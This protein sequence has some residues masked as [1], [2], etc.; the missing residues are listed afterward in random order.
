[1]KTKWNHFCEKRVS[2]GMFFT[3]FHKSHFAL[4]FLRCTRV[5]C[6]PWFTTTHWAI[7]PLLR[8]ENLVTCTNSVNFYLFFFWALPSFYG[9][10]TPARFGLGFGLQTQWLHCTKQNFHTAW[11][12][13]QIPI[14]T[15][16]Y[17]N[18]IGIWVRTK[19]HLSQCTWAITT[20]K[21]SSTVR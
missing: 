14:Q 12:Q 1:M 20:Q 8:S 19:V 10:F 17:R 21:F 16:N 11:S 2:V 15:A 3:S 6:T 5:Q 9:L 4:A 18:G 7:S 13:I